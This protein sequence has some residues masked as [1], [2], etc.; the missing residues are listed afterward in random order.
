MTSPAANNIKIS[1]DLDIPDSLCCPDRS[2]T[3]EDR[4]IV[5]HILPDQLVLSDEKIADPSFLRKFF[6]C[7]FCNPPSASTFAVQTYKTYLERRNGNPDVRMGLRISGLNLDQMHKQN[8]PLLVKHVLS[9]SDSIDFWK[10][11]RLK[12]RQEF[13]NCEIYLLMQKTATAAAD[14]PSHPFTIQEDVRILVDRH[15]N[16]GRAD[17]FSNDNITSMLNDLHFEKELN[18][19]QKKDVVDAVKQH[20][21]QHYKI[22]H[23]PE[24]KVR[25]RPAQKKILV[26]EEDLS[27]ILA[28]ILRKPGHVLKR[29]ILLDH[30][31][32]ATI[33][34]WIAEFPEDA[35]LFI[36]Y[37]FFQNPPPPKPT[38]TTGGSAG[39]PAIQAPPATK[40]QKHNA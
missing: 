3:W 17:V 27:P 6:C 38:T 18:A 34:K 23:V 19:D 29:P 26:P 35:D 37:Q 7:H 24:D 22:H 9:V 21:L 8:E 30:F 2:T 1:V 11:V 12:I 36:L 32:L 20:I 31:P 15:T 4:K 25:G 40:D 13:I 5:V 16:D 14:Q 33:E 39:Q 10:K 28:A